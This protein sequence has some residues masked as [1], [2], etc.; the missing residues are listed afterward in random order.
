MTI[1]Q[2]PAQAVPML[3]R[4]TLALSVSRPNSHSQAK[5]QGPVSFA[6]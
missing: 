4:G 5:P 3:R 1:P 2:R 6:R